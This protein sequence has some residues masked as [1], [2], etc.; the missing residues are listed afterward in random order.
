M[1]YKYKVRELTPVEDDIVNVAETKEMEAMSL[2]KLRRKL[3]P[4]KK[5]HEHHYSLYYPH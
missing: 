3:D 2:K 4:K 1:R 5:Y